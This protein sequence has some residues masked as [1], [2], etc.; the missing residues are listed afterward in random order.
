MTDGSFKSESK[1]NICGNYRVGPIDSTECTPIHTFGSTIINNHALDGILS[2]Q[3]FLIIHTLQFEYNYLQVT[4]F[5][6][7]IKVQIGNGIEQI[8]A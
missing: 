1:L 3:V 8:I 7:G 6:H 4:N 5:H 2:L